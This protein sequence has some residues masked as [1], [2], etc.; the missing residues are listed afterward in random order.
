LST[1]V[2]GGSLDDVT[3]RFGGLFDIAYIDPPW[4]Y[5][6]DPNK[7]GA[8]GKHYSLMSEAD[9][10][11]LPVRKLFGKRG[12]AF[13]W[14]TGP[15]MSMAYRCI[16]AWGLYDR[17]LGAVWIKTSKKTGKVIGAQGVRPSHV[18]QLDEFL[19]IA[20]TVPTG[21][22]FPLLTE[23]QEQ[24][25]FTPRGAHSWKPPVFRERITQLFGDRPRIEL[26]AR[27]TAPGWH[28]W[29]HGVQ[30]QNT[31]IIVTP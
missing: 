12:V 15:K 5:D 29:G 17:G 13:V 3:T 18:K 16:A 6:G 22:T 10:S 28:C 11:A 8:A 31:P 24:N 9:I 25:V 14:A 1:F 4:P 19:I 27:E 23:S 2:H 26:F 7:M 30:S 21:R 20:S